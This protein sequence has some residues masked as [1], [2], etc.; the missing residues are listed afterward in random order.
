MSRII[1][2]ALL[3]AVVLMPAGTALPQERSEGDRF[4]FKVGVASVNLNVVVTDKN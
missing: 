3:G 4:Q 1:T 2:L